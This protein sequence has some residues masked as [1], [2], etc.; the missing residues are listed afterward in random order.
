[1]RTLRKFTQTALIEFAE[2]FCLMVPSL[3]QNRAKITKIR[4]KMYER[5]EFFC[6]RM[7]KKKNV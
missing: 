6:K 2:V 3:K 5:I 4:Q 1:M 7:K